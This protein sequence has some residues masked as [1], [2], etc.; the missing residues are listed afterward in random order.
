M[1]DKYSE[2]VPTP[3]DPSAV[4]P[5]RPWLVK[6]WIL[7][8]Q[9]T[10]L[11]GHGYVGKSLVALQLCIAVASADK[12]WLGMGVEHGR[13][14]ALWCEDD[15]DEMHRRIADVC[16]AEGVKIGSLG[17]FV[18]SCCTTGG[19]AFFDLQG[20]TSVWE[21]LHDRL[22][23]LRPRLIVLDEADDLLA[24]D[25]R[26]SGR[27]FLRDLQDLAIKTDAAVV[28]LAHPARDGRAEWHDSVRVRLRLS[29][30]GS[31]LVDD[32]ILAR[33]KSNYASEKDATR[34][35][36]WEAGRFRTT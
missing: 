9:V 31:G 12:T 10:L 30:R 36:H 16:R 27:K 17:N 22:V 11:T 25:G 4:V 29:A 35:L 34:A 26:V 23:Q 21:K 13:A 2:I 3:F 14:F 19:D 1:I 8:R 7:R 28:V 18:Y 20:A 32:R 6:D 15:A 33:E 5:L 24:D